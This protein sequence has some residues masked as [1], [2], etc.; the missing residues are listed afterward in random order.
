MTEAMSVAGKP[1]PRLN[2]PQTRFLVSSEAPHGLTQCT[3]ELTTR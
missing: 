3:S 2:Q 1:A